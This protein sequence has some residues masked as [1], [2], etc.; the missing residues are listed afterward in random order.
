MKRKAK[1]PKYLAKKPTKKAENQ[2][3][4][5]VKAIYQDPSSPVA[6]TSPKKV[7]YEFKKR[8]VYLNVGR[9]RLAKYLSELDDYTLYKHSNK[10]YKTSRVY[11]TR[12]NQQMSIDLADV[13]R[14]SN[15]N[16]NVKYLLVGIND[17]SRKAYVYPLKSKLSNSVN[18]AMERMLDLVKIDTLCSDLGS[19]FKSKT[20]HDLL[21]KYKISHF[22]AKGS[23][24]CVLIER[25]IRTLRGRIARYK[26][27]YN[28]NRYIDKLAII[29]TGY[30]NTV[31]RSIQMTPNM[32]NK[33]NE[34]EVYNN[35]YQGKLEI[36]TKKPFKFKIR[37]AVR[38]S[39]AKHLFS[40]ESYER[41]S[42]EI[43][44]ISQRFRNP[45]N[46]NVYEVEDC[47]GEVLQGR[48]R[49]PELTMVNN[50]DN[51][52]HKI[53]AFLDEKVDKGVKMVLVKYTD[54]PRKCA[55]WE[56]KTAIIDIIEEK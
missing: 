4:K 15:D 43:F 27:A 13:S 41:W 19:E 25:F 20:F 46:F 30:N 42:R 49:E 38:L 10:R 44:K 35:L 40:K 37:Q 45:Q 55:T 31:H 7:L 3:R 28:T 17:F 24:K 1:I 50:Y 29:V 52:V 12:M 39:G 9:S 8:G 22:F 14:S 56:R 16:D 33:T 34:R 51:K 18:L 2:F 48:F 54:F 53:E 26:S 21:R 32:V 5:Y 47:A 23:S 11:V 6:F 36:Y